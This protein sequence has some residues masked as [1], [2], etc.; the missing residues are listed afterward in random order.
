M[1]S[2]NQLNIKDFSNKWDGLYYRIPYEKNVIFLHHTAGL[3]IYSSE[4]WLRISSSKTYR[5]R[6]FYVGVNYFI[7]LDGTIIKAIPDSYWAWH[8]GTGNSSIDRSSISI[9]LEN[10][11][12]LNKVSDSIFLDLYNRKWELEKIDGDILFL[13]HKSFYGGDLKIKVKK[14]KKWRL[15]EYYHIYSKEQIDSLI[16]LCKNLFLNNPVPKKILSL[17]EFLPENDIYSKIKDFKGVVNHS[18]FLG[19]KIKWDLSIAFSDW[20]YYF[21]DNLNLNIV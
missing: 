7:G 4:E 13:Y 2:I 1:E 11:G 19:S 5:E 18:Q 10:L 6:G 8:S 17:N 12:F 9:E 14:F 16:N 3:N 15:F 20:Y 21:A